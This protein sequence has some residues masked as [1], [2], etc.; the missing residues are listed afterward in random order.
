[1][2]GSI[3]ESNF[4]ESVSKIYH[5]DLVCNKGVKTYVTNFFNLKRINLFYG[6]LN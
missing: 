4:S 6:F 2:E 3:L 1:M 5:F